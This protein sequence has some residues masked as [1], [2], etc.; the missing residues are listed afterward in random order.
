MKG[1]LA[2]YVKI[3]FVLQALFIA[4]G[5]VSCLLPDQPVKE[6]IEQSVRIYEKEH[7]YPQHFIKKPGHQSDNFMDFLIM[8]MIYNMKSGDLVNSMLLPGGHA[9]YDTTALA[10][11][12][13]KYSTEHQESP[14]SFTYGRYWQGS[15][16]A[17]RFLF[18]IADLNGVRWLNFMACSLVIFV[19]VGRI[20]NAMKNKEKYPLLLGLIFVNYYMVFTSFQFAPVFL[21]TLIGGLS[22]VNR[23]DKQKETVT[24]FLILGSLT[25]YFDLLTA[26]LLTLCIP[27]LIGIIL[28]A[29]KKKLLEGLNDIFKRSGIWLAGYVATWMVKWGLV[30]AF[31]DYSIFNDVKNKMGERAGTWQGSRFHTIKANVDMLELVPLALLLV[32]SILLVA[33]FF[34]RDGIKKAMLFLVVALFPFVWFFA[35]ANHSEMHNWFTYRTLWI[36]VSGLLLVFSSLID[37]QALRNISAKKL[38]KPGD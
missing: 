30:S 20:S 13:V 26:P 32:I 31:T 24:L 10:I 16:F 9:S 5:V 22:L 29:N 21:I 28:Q 7:V 34:N 12:D 15:T 38:F 27:L 25:C 4:F 23:I 33:F 2:A 8:N 37:W 36:S 6:H 35:T 3:F 11:S 1:T 18:V 14:L 17:Y 19:F